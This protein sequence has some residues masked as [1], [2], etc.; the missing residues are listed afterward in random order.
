MQSNAER[1]YELEDAV[2]RCLR[3]FRECVV[4]EFAPSSWG[5]WG[6]D[7][8]ILDPP[9]E[10]PRWEGLPGEHPIIEILHKVLQGNRRGHHAD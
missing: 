7:E 1:I 9:F 6:S 8:I 10:G 5:S 4:I 3:L 2:R